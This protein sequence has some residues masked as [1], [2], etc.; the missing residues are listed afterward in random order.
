MARS[1]S[2][3]VLGGGGIGGIAWQIG[4]LAGLSHLGLDL[5]QAK[6]ILGTS[7]GSTVGAQLTGSATLEERYEAQLA[8]VPY[9]I[10]KSF[11]GLNLARYLLAASLP[12]SLQRASQRIGHLA[13]GAD[14][15]PV[16][17]R[18]AVIEKRLPNSEWSDADLRLVVVDAGTGEHRILTRNDDVKL[19]DAVAASCAVPLVWPPIELEGRFYIDGGARTPV[20]LDL[21][22][23]TG[24]VVAL[25]P[26]T[27]SFKRVGTISAQRRTLGERPVEIIKPSPE[28]RKAQGRNPLDKTVVPAVARAGW[29]QARAEI[30]RIKAMLLQKAQ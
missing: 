12:G 30:S 19:A 14:V 11:A 8:G 25:A 18:R 20:N 3:L 7:A 17:E 5:R 27:M 15:G 6:S 29:E 13:R 22:P 24:P 21:A 2:T 16:E 28:A 4:L 9:E 26:L 10:S 23:G 1:D